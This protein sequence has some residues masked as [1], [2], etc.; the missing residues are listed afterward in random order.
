[1]LRS[2]ATPFSPANHP[3]AGRHTSLGRH[4][5]VIGGSIAGLA[6]ARVLSDYFD[7]V[8]ILER[9]RYPEHARFRPGVPQANHLHAL[10]TR[11]LEVAE[12]LFPGI[13][14]GLLESGAVEMD[15]GAE[16]AWLVRSGWAVRFDGGP[17][18]LSFS[19][20]LLDWHVRERVNQLPNVRIIDNCEVLELLTG[21]NGKVTGARA[22][23]RNELGDAHDTFAVH[24]D[25]VVD[26]SGRRSKTREWL[27][28]LGVDAAA[29]ISIDASIGYASRVYRRP[30]N[31]SAWWKAIL[32]QLAPP[33]RTRGA[34]MF[35]IE[36]D[37]WLVTLL[38]GGGD[39]PPI[40]PDGFLAFARSLPT[41]LFA[42]AM[43]SAEPLSNPVGYRNTANVRR[44]YDRLRGMPDRFFVTGDAACAFNPVYGQGMSVALL[45][46][47]A[48]REC[49]A[50]R[51]ARARENRSLDG[52]SREAQ[53]RVMEVSAPSW[54]LATSEDYR[55][56]L[57]EGAAP[58][59]QV[60]LMHRYVDRVVALTTH[61]AAVRKAWLRVMMMLDP[62]S[63]I[64][65][66][67]IVAKALFSAKPKP[68]LPP[69]E[70]RAF[71]SQDPV[72]Q[73]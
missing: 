52:L 38:G 73:I 61:D 20:P 18:V 70:R 41:P 53:A 67:S 49:L 1:M 69:R 10:L 12:E 72:E 17:K 14:Q 42:D 56:P 58:G 48:F 55:F 60:K 34:L 8:T 15:V 66:P 46:A 32:V 26:A 45:E 59:L 37:R 28:A 36:G 31:H 22:K 30:P 47:I 21:P 64:F 62:P 29:E 23:F 57:V 19:R 40:D 6:H 71:H 2:N 11:G 65:A 9:D 68:I 16:G 35:P 44:Q 39:Y 33:E 4:A 54:M 63:S 50:R 13:C 7:K 25:L 43:E 3:A 27:G 24:A 5:I 51:A